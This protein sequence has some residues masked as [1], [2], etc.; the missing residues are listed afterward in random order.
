MD[1]INAQFDIWFYLCGQLTNNFYMDSKTL[2]VKKTILKQ[3]HLSI[4]NYLMF[5]KTISLN[6]MKIKVLISILIN[7][8]KYET[9]QISIVLTF[10]FK[11]VV[12]PPTK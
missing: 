4:K 8:L 2:N 12:Q 11:I 3:M 10:R 9:D 1:H 7:L 6:E 5:R